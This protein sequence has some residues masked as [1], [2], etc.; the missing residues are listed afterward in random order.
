[1]SVPPSWKLKLLSVA[2]LAGQ[3]VC[4]R[5]LGSDQTAGPGVSW[6]L[7]PGHQ[8]SIAM[9]KVASLFST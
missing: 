9:K 5:I 4:S 8:E 7:L 6:P 1:M 3:E 2:L